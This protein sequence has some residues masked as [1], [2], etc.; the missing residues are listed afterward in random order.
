[1]KGCCLQNCG[2]EKSLIRSRENLN[3]KMK[4]TNSFHYLP[5]ITSIKFELSN[6]RSG[7]LILNFTSMYALLN[8]IVLQ[9]IYMF[10]CFCNA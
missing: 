10:V 8:T 5:I 1:M 4:K 9:L 7:Y 2:S 3:Y 6:T